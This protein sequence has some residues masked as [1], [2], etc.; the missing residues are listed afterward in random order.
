MA[1]TDNLIDEISQILEQYRREVP[2]KR[3]P[4]PASVKKRVLELQRAK[5]HRV[6]W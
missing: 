2:G 1:H 6:G 3:S 5:C 4:L